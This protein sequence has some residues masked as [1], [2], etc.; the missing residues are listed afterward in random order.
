ME[1]Y[2]NNAY[3]EIFLHD[4]ECKINYDNEKQIL[5]FIFDVGFCLKDDGKGN[6]ERKP[7]IIQIS[8]LPIE[9]ITIKTFKLRNYLGHFKMIG[10]HCELSDFHNFFKNYY[11]QVYDEYYAYQT[12]L[13]RGIPYPCY[14]KHKFDEF[15]IEIYLGN[16][17]IEY[18]FI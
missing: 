3:P 7:G 5:Q 8:N 13:L 4:C 17:P 1:F 12:L 16:S 14:P 10:K 6:I 11:F 2:K 15:E 9:E 18:H